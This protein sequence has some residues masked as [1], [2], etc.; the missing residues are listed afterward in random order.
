MSE[1]TRNSA[2]PAPALA[3]AAP[4]LRIAVAP[5]PAPV[6][7]AP[8]ILTPTI[9]FATTTTTTTQ[10]NWCDDKLVLGLI[11]FIVLTGGIGT[12]FWGISRLSEEIKK[13][14]NDY[15]IAT[16]VLGSITIFLLCCLLI[17][18]LL[19]DHSYNNKI[20]ILIVFITTFYIATGIGYI[21]INYL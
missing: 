19:C 17:A 20:N 15:I 14:K 7:T 1:I 11:V 3:P 16:Y 18:I 6:P 8:A 13:K 5:A 12:L 4:A 21:F 2:K 9:T 10:N